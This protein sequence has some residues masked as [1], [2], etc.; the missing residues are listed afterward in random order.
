MLE[1]WRALGG[2]EDLGGLECFVV[3]RPGSGTPVLW[4]HGFASSSLDWR[5]ALDLLPVE[6][7]SLAL[8]NGS[9]YIIDQG[10]PC[11]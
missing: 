4:L 1:Q 3:D 2:A 6:I 10:F 5:R 9:V 7:S 8:T 11:A